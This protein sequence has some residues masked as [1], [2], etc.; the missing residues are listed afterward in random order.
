LCRA[1]LLAV[2]AGTS[3]AATFLDPEILPLQPG[4]G[5]S[6]LIERPDQ[7]FH[8]N[9]FDLLVDLRLFLSFGSCRNQGQDCRQNGE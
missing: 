8:I 6:V 7:D 3:L 2:V 5:Q 4:Y 9:H 1:V